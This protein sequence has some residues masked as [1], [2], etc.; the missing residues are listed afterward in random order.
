MGKVECPVPMDA[1]GNLR[2][3][4]TLKNYNRWSQELK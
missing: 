4:C 1:E 2:S 3:D